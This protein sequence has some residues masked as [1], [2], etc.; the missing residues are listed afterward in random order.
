[1][2][3]LKCFFPQKKMLKFQSSTEL[4]TEY[5]TYP[6]LKRNRYPQDLCRGSPAQQS[7]V[8]GPEIHSYENVPDPSVSTFLTVT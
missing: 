2:E 3:I 8:P 7:G 5:H 4:S 1:M 6:Q